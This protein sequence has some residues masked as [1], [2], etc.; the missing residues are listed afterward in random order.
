MGTIILMIIVLLIFL[1]LVKGFIGNTDVSDKDIYPKDIN[2]QEK[3]LP[4]DNDVINRYVAVYDDL[5]KLTLYIPEHKHTWNDTLAKKM[6][7]EVS[8]ME[9]KNFYFNHR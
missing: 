5:I 7:M 6:G 4:V 1:I 8:I 9:G 3:L 2:V